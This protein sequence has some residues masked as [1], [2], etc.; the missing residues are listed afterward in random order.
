VDA[1]VML[2]EMG[3]ANNIRLAEKIAGIDVVLS[4]DM[5]EETKVPVVAKSGTVLLEEGQDGTMVGELKLKVKNHRVA[6]W[7]FK[8][9]RIDASL[10]EDPATAARI[11]E[12]RKPFLAGPAFK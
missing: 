10:P 1:V 7:D 4:S 9:H 3:L 6:M 12:I 8:F 11:A 5:H 2:S